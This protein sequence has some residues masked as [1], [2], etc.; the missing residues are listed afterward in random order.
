MS[1][2]PRAKAAIYIKETA[3]YPN[4]ENS[5]ESNSTTARR[6]LSTTTSTS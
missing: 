1:N 5:K 4:G 2:T 6:S 3:G